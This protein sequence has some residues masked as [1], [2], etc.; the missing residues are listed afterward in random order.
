MGLA[1]DFEIESLT[2]PLREAATRAGLW[3]PRNIPAKATLLHQGD[4]SDVVFVQEGGL[5]RL[6]YETAGGDLRVKSFI[7]DRGFFAAGERPGE[8]Q[9]SA[10]SAQC[11]E[12]SIL[13]ELP[14]RFVVAAVQENAELQAAYTGFTNWVRRRKQAREEALLC[15]SA[16]ARYLSFLRDEPGLAAR[17]PQGDIARFL[18]VTPIAFSRIKKRVARG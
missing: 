2:G 3:R 7:A 9:P 18:G 14:L 8:P 5:T 11:L 13:A 15:Q 10:F 17:L 6:A 16:E 12:P 4:R 1:R